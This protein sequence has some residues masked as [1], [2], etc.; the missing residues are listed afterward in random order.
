ME[1]IAV[2]QLYD[3][4]ASVCAIKVRLVLAEKG[5][6]WTGH[7]VDLH[8][9]GQFDPAYAKINPKSVVPTLV[10]GGETIVESTVICEYLDEAFPEPPLKPADPTGRARMRLWTKAVDENL[11]EACVAVTFIALH[12]HRYLRRP[13]DEID[14]LIDRIPDRAAREARRRYVFDGF[15]GPDVGNAMRT[16]DETLA[17][18]EE[19]LADSPWLA[20]QGY[21][22]ADIALTPYVNRL[23][24]LGFSEAWEPARPNVCGWFRRIQDR[25]SFQGAVRNHWPEG[26]VEDIRDTA[27]ASLPRLRQALSE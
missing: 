12:R 14:A 27:E 4:W 21:S 2:L 17:R 10:H 18:M 20:G 19:T 1:G 22:L 8:H 11:H 16:Y 26:T 6:D 3:H 5:L 15:D 9:G 24:M 25:P 23:A 7:F 13:R